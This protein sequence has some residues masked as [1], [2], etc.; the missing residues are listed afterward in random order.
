[1]EGRH[2]WVMRVK[3]EVMRPNSAPF[4]DTVVSASHSKGIG[5]ALKQ[6][7][8]CRRTVHLRTR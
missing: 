6:L 8:T 4:R 5:E 1:M 2:A 7:Q 3:T